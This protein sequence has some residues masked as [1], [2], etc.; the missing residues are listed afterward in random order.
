MMSQQRSQAAHTED[1][2]AVTLEQ[3][4]DPMVFLKAAFNTMRQCSIFF[5]AP[6][7]VR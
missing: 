4:D 3:S 7:M 5:T 1:V 6:S 2:L